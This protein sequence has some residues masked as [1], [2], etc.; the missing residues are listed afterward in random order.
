MGLERGGTDAPKS[1]NLD[2]LIQ[3]VEPIHPAVRVLDHRFSTAFTLTSLPDVIA[4]AGSCAARARGAQMVGN[5]PPVYGRAF[6]MNL[7]FR[8]QSGETPVLRTLWLNEA[9]GWRIASYDVETP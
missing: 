5:A 2:E 4:E 3:G 8:T 1:R 9:G 6:G 7:R